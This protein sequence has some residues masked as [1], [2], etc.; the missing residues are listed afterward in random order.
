MSIKMSIIKLKQSSNFPALITAF[1]LSGMFI[2]NALASDD[3]KETEDDQT[4]VKVRSGKIP[5]D[6]KEKIEQPKLK[7]ARI[8][9]ASFTPDLPMEVWGIIFSFVVNLTHYEL[10]NITSINQ[11]IHSECEDIREIYNKLAS[12]NTLAVRNNLKYSIP[13]EKIRDFHFKRRIKFNFIEGFV[14]NNF[15]LPPFFGTAINNYSA[16]DEDIK[17]LNSFFITIKKIDKVRVESRALPRDRPALNLFMKNLKGC[18][19][20]CLQIMQAPVLKGESRQEYEEYFLS[21]LWPSIKEITSLRCL[22]ICLENADNLNYIVRN[23]TELDLPLKSFIM[24]YTQLTSF[25]ADGVA[26]L[27]ANSSFL[28]TLKVYDIETNLESFSPIVTSVKRNPSFE[29]FKI[30]V[31]SDSNDFGEDEDEIRALV[32]ESNKFKIF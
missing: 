19:L 32:K 15:L 14:E 11:D 5:R 12:G 27:I 9:E 24:G 1:F 25:L 16:N 23:I 17:S 21:D 22:D 20:R 28:K 2:Q 6:D 4:Y 8:E 30:D 18:E 7:D 3:K 10:L 29:K 26:L 31:R 13:A